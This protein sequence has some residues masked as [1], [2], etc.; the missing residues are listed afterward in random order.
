MRFLLGF[1]LIF[2]PLYAADPAVGSLPE[3]LEQNRLLLAQVR[4]QQQTINELSSKMVELG[5]VSERHERALATRPERGEA[6]TPAPRSAGGNR[7]LRVSAEAGFAFFNTGTLGQFPK[8]EFRVDDAMLTFEAPV[9]RNTYFFADLRLLSREAS[10]DRPD[11][12]ELY[13]DFEDVSANW[14]QPGLM[15]L[16]V[17]RLNIPFG[18]E[19]LVRN[20]LDNPLISHSLADF[21]GVDEGVEI[22]GK[23]GPFQY[24]LALQNGGHAKLRDFNADKAIVGRLSWSPLAWLSLSGSAMRTGEV[25]AAAG[26]DV[27]AE[28]W[29]GNNGWFKGVV[30]PVFARTF[31]V[32][33]WQAEATA[34]WREGHLGIAVGAAD[35]GDNDRRGDNSR[36]LRFGSVEAVHYFDKRIFG[37]ARQSW[38]NVPKGY[39][40]AGWGPAATYFNGTVLTS[41][42]RRTSVGIGYRFGPPLVLKFEY[43][44]ESRLKTTSA[45]RENGNLLGLELGLKL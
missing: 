36:R 23:A 30:A 44:W 7:E 6:A 35:Y 38:I 16:R 41:E 39:P 32:S 37:A 33:L 29:I 11:I 45:Q 25:S 31:W 17:G 21:W 8:A 28:L 20:P 27:Y 1:I 2:C 18:E 10:S 22:Y 12:G 5:K 26:T 24:V 15:S 3:I 13:V 34:R 19:Y 43:A 4:A 42:I 40:L 9:V 14:G